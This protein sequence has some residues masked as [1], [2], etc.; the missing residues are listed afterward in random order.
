[1]SH[2][3]LHTA[4]SHKRGGRRRDSGP[5]PIQTRLNAVC[6]LSSLLGCL[7][8]LSGACSSVSFASLLAARGKEIS[9]VLGLIW[10]REPGRPSQTSALWIFLPL[11]SLCMICCC[12][13][14]IACFKSAT[15]HFLFKS[16]LNSQVKPSSCYFLVPLQYLLMSL[17][18]EL[19]L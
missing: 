3:G 16:S 15:M 6:V 19:N 2:K 8:G 11:T 18:S 9:S 17:N 12:L 5:V 10:L 7:P 4:V 13:Q 14:T 1:M